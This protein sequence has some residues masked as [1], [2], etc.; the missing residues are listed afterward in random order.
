MDF[1]GERKKNKDFIYRYL[2]LCSGR[3]KM[4]KNSDYSW[5]RKLFPV[6]TG[7]IGDVH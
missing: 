1:Q 5:T 4:S 2:D 6:R 7:K 3:K